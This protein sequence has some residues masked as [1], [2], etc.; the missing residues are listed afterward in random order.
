MAPKWHQKTKSP[1][2]RGFPYSR[3]IAETRTSHVPPGFATFVRQEPSSAYGVSQ[4]GICSPPHSRGFGE[5]DPFVLHF[6]PPSP[7]GPPGRYL[8]SR[9][10]KLCF[11]V[12]RLPIGLET[13]KSAAISSHVVTSPPETSCNFGEFFHC[14]ADVLRRKNFL[15]PFCG[16]FTIVFMT[17]VQFNFPN[18]ATIIPCVVKIFCSIKNFATAF[19]IEN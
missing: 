4:G 18:F 14:F 3:S 12:S 7:A 11:I 2:S 13:T 1:Y 9:A 19:I 16:R 10:G 17:I 5:C 15:K 8:Y 6:M